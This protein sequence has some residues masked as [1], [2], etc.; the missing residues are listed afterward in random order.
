M[1]KTVPFVWKVSFYTT[2]VISGDTGIER[3]CDKAA[4]CFSGMGLI[5]ALGWKAESSGFGLFMGIYVWG[6]LGRLCSGS[7]RSTVGAELTTPHCLRVAFWD[8]TVL[9]PN[10]FNDKACMQFT[11]EASPV[12]PPLSGTK[13]WQRPVAL[14]R[15]CHAVKLCY[16]FY[17]DGLEASM[18][19]TGQKAN[20]DWSCP[21]AACHP[22]VSAWKWN[23]SLACR[24]CDLQASAGHLNRW[25]HLS[26]TTLL[27]MM[28][29][30]QP[31]PHPQHPRQ[32]STRNKCFI[33]QVNCYTFALKNDENHSNGATAKIQFDLQCVLQENVHL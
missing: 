5:V 2:H 14:K 33:I 12:R 17:L 4:G 16:C 31:K 15:S 26:M 10:T 22:P 19:Y 27:Q 11:T 7:L 28:T 20:V 9:A 29:Q 13:P 32:V 1:T 23:A 24:C 6:T 8:K 3:G 25:V 18:Y 30:P 21:K